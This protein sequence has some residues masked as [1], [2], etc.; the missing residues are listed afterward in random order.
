METLFKKIRRGSGLNK[1]EIE[2]LKKL[3][4]YFLYIAVANDFLS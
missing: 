3:S 2:E 4:S 1:A